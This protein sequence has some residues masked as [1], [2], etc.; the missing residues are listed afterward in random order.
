MWKFYEI[1]ILAPRNKIFYKCIAMP[2]CLHMVYGY[3]CATVAELNSCNK[4]LI[5]HCRHFA[6]LHCKLQGYIYNLTRF[7]VTCT[8]LYCSIY[9][10]F[11]YQWTLTM[12]NKK[13]RERWTLNG[14]LL[15]P[16]WPVDSF[17]IKL[18]DKELFIT[19]WHYSHAQY[20]FTLPN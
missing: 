12:S 7:Q 18:N 1:Q 10:I 15:R 3:F 11:Y 19:Q 14:I 8:S 9:F 17:V 6:L 20:M 13:R 5:W 2:I 4:D 16:Q